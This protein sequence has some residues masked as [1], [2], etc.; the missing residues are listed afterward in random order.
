MT[1]SQPWQFLREGVSTTSQTQH[2]RRED[3]EISSEV[4]GG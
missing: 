2:T 1:Y 3:V 4:M